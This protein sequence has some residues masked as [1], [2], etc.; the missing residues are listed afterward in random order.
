MIIVLRLLLFGLYYFRGDTGKTLKVVSYLLTASAVF[1]HPL[2]NDVGSSGE[3]IFG[4]GYILSEIAC[5][6]RRRVGAIAGHDDFSQR[7]ESVFTGDLCARAAFRL[8]WQ[9]E[10]LEIGRGEC[11]LDF[12][13]QFG[14]KCV[15]SLYGLKNENLPVGQFPELVEAFGYFE[16][17]HFVETSGHLFAI[18]RN[19]RDGGAFGKKF[20]G[21]AYAL[22]GN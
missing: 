4:G 1:A 14:C 10:I 20:K 21:V 15:L 19:E 11:A 6:R 2:G 7:F 16:N 3:G 22:F 9:V 5:G 18:T 13:T 12:F 17:R 8:I